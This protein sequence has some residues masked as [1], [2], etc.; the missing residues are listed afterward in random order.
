MQYLLKIE[1]K[2]AREAL[3]SLGLGIDASLEDLVSIIFEQ[4]TLD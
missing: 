4:S 3:L 2:R 1:A